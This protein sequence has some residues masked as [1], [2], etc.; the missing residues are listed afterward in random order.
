VATLRADQSRAVTDRKNELWRT[1]VLALAL[2]LLLFLGSIIV[3]PAVTGETRSQRLVLYWAVASPIGGAI[4]AIAVR[5]IGRRWARRQRQQP[6]ST[7]Q[8][9]VR[10][11]AFAAPGALGVMLLW[12]VPREVT[13]SDLVWWRVAEWIAA[14]V[15]LTVAIGFLGGVLPELTARWA[16]RK[17]PTREDET[18][19][20]G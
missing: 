17:R 4:G 3:V 5:A 8:I 12:V 6:L 15:G 19:P 20:K 13:P 14:F 10:S 11:L 16:R 2:S 9:I 1:I 7:R 18:D